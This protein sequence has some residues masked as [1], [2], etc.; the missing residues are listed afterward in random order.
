MFVT[1]RCNFQVFPA[2]RRPTNSILPLRNLPFVIGKNLLDFV[3]EIVFKLLVDKTDNKFRI[4]LFN[5]LLHT[6]KSL[7]S[8]LRKHE[9]K[10]QSSLK[11]APPR[12]QRH[13][14]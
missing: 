12:P 13:P 11:A 8:V 1:Q 14:R 3:E 4:H 6:A 7:L 10:E 9:G 2:S 5:L